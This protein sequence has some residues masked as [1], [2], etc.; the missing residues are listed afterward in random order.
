MIFPLFIGFLTGLIGYTIGRSSQ[1]AQ[2]ITVT[3]TSGV[4][5]GKT[6]RLSPRTLPPPRQA[7]YVEQLD[8]CVIE[9]LPVPP[10][11]VR[12]ALIESHRKGDM[13][14][15]NAI[16]LLFRKPEA[17]Q[18]EAKD[19]EETETV[20]GASEETSE[21]KSPIEGVSDGDWMDFVSK[22]RVR[23]PSYSTNTHL[24]AY[25]HNRSRLQSLG[26]S[27][28][29]E[30]EQEQYSALVEDLT[31]H[32]SNARP[33]IDEF[34]GDSVTLDGNEVPISMSGVL[35]LLKAGGVQGA[36]KWLRD[37][38]ARANYP[39]TKDLFLRANGCF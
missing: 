26:F 19:A 18:E 11:L 1:P 23:E 21:I 35:A 10:G 9:K 30:S 6:R 29:L 31:D 25:E 3:K 12:L 13:G 16:A 14:T 22:L 33:L 39:R 32:Y 4:D 37:P 7:S 20:E 36:E 27:E 5:I 28:P 38:Q 24:G 17:K 2:I 34:C 15:F 8:R